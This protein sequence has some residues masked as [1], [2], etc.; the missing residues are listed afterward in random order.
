MNREISIAKTRVSLVASRRAFDIM[1]RSN[2]YQLP[3]RDGSLLYILPPMR[4]S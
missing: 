3:S 2:A 4:D 1:G